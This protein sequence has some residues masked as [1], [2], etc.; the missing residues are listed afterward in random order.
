MASHDMHEPLRKITTF[1]QRLQKE[2]GATLTEDGV[3]YL[4][5]MLNAAESMS[6]LID[7]LL[8]YSRISINKQAYQ[9][10]DLTE[11]VNESIND[12]DILISETGV[13][14]STEPMPE[15][16]SIPSQMRQL[17]TNILHNAIKFRK[18]DIPLVVKIRQEKLD[19]A[20]KKS[21]NL[22]VA[23]EYYLIT[24]SDNG[25]GLEQQYAEKIFQIFQRLEGKSEYPGTGIGLSICRKIVTNHKGLI[26][27]TGAPGEG[28]ILSIILPKCQ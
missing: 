15:I 2:L 18:K 27:A 23:K 19:L 21:Y 11:I 17:F 4:S 8:Q 13:T 10:V 12:L 5:R 9:T 28:T 1:G 25:I 24:I 3:L 7:N 22:S 26:F 16:E 14:I 20:D 6:N